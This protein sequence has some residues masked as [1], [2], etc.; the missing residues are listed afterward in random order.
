MRALANGAEATTL[1]AVQPAFARAISPATRLCAVLG[2]PVRHS[3]SPAMHNAAFAAL[4]MDWRYVAHA[5]KPEH[6]GEALRGACRLGYA[7]VNLTVPHKSEALRLVD[8]A[9]PVSTTL[10]AVNTV[11]FEALRDGEW[12]SP[13]CAG[14]CDGPVR[15]HGYNTDADALLRALREDLAIEPR[16]ARVLLLGAGG[17]GQA[18][19]RRLADEGVG[20]L[21][22]VNRTEA[23]AEALAREL[24]AA[25]P[26]VDVRVGYPA[27]DIEIVI[28]ATSSGLRSDDPLPYDAARF[29]PG[30]ADAAYDMIYRPAETPFL[31]GAKSAG[32]RTANGVGM[33]LYQGA[34]A[35]ELWTGRS[36]PIDVMR[37]ALEEEI[38]GGMR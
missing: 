19:A 21:H 8:L 14:A 36:A 24:E 10:Q 13:G 11:V 1:A 35:F 27:G 2:W 18:A 9:D 20:E 22:L 12:T 15:M 23:K 31:R 32:C 37:G 26:A 30:Q 7:G 16:A 33:L 38:Y 29:S 34:A 4:G 17:A 6:L 5:V 28:N 25:H 3:A